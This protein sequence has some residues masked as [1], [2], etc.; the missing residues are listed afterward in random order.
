MTMGS[1]ILK[2][3]VPAA[4][5]IMVER[6]R[7]AGA[8]FIGKT[9]TPEFGLGSHT[10][11][12]GLRRDA[13]RLRPVALGRRQQR[14]RRGG[15][16]AAHAAGRRRQ[17]LRRQPAQPRRLEQRASAF[18][19]ASAACRPTAATPG[20]RRWACS[21]RWRGTVAGPRHAA[22]GPGRL[23]RARA[24]VDRRRRATMFRAPLNV[25]LKGKRDRLGRRLQ[26]RRAVRARRAG[27][28]RARAARRSRRL[29]AS[30]RR[31]CR[32]IRSMQVWQAWLRPAR[33]AERRHPCSPSTRI[34]PSARCSSPRRSSRSKAGCKLSAYDITAA[35]ARAHRVVP[36]GAAAVRTLRLSRSCPT[37]QLFPFDAEMNWPRRSL[38]GR[39][40]PTTNG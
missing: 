16:G 11:N 23:R 21:G 20:C 17:R 33:L 22:L 18:A 27:G 6:L 8:I 7:S 15:A 26:R 9:N 24:V 35:S 31:R 30:S 3:F 36:G 29:G 39:C 12:P 38:A 2:D 25:D 32:T 13:Q 14:R 37:A 19:R 40:T 1:P 34:R 4:D 10:Y 28:L 5:S